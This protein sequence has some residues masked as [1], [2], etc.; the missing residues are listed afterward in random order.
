VSD[1]AVKKVKDTEA[2]AKK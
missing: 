2:E 1:D